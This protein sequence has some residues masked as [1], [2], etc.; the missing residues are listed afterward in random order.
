MTAGVAENILVVGANAHAGFMPWDWAALTEGKPSDEEAYRFAT[1]RY[2]HH[3]GEIMQQPCG[4]I[5]LLGRETGQRD[6]TVG[7]WCG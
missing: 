5:E 4:R 1:H 6:V 2:A 7:R 3:T